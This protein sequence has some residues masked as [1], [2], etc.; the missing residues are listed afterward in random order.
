M[1]GSAN[2]WLTPEK[3]A[4]EN[5]IL[6]SDSI[7][8]IALTR[9]KNRMGIY[10]EIRKPGQIDLSPQQ[11]VGAGRIGGGALQRPQSANARDEAAFLRHHALHI[12][13]T[14]G[15]ICRSGAAAVGVGAELQAAG[16][17]CADGGGRMLERR[18]RGQ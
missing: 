13:G 4:R 5:K 12:T 14:D 18:A 3:L 17:I 2:P 10:L 1:V 16:L 9:E 7:D 8:A 15:Q 11:R 6:K